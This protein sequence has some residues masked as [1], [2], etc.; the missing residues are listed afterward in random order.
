M[1]KA[2][3]QWSSNCLFEFEN[4][5]K[6]CQEY[7]S[8]ADL[9]FMWTQTNQDYDPSIRQG[10]HN[11]DLAYYL[12]FYLA[13]NYVLK[14]QRLVQTQLDILWPETYFKYVTGV[15]YNRYSNFMCLEM[16]S[17]VTDFNLEVK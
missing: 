6:F 13:N 11:L 8:Y 15:H 10:Y 7:K 16:Y 12:K 3:A 17:D 9:G 1:V 14:L 2:D 4:G 5:D